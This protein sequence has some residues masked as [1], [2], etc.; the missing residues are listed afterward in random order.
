MR[1]L[2]ALYNKYNQE[3]FNG[4]LPAISLKYNGRIKRCMG[5]YNSGRKEIDIS[6]VFLTDKYI[7]SALDDTLIHEMIHAWQDLVLHIPGDH[8]KTFH[9]M[10]RYANTFGHQIA[11]K[12]DPRL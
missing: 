9:Q 11:T 5:Y 3:I 1:D 10:A 2:Y 6:K 12:F 7:P 8:R 4:Q